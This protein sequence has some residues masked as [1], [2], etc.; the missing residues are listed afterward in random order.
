MLL[1]Y[2]GDSSG[3]RREAQAL[4]SSEWFLLLNYSVIKKICLVI[5]IYVLGFFLFVCFD[6]LCVDFF[7]FN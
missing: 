5:L 3:G 4:P 2:H 7:L 6:M 1:M